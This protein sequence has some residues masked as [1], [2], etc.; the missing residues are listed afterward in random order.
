MEVKMENTVLGA[1][2]FMPFLL[3]LPITNTMLSACRDAIQGKI[4]E[5]LSWS[6]LTPLP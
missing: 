1:Q 6:N 2:D 3:V 5:S 4:L